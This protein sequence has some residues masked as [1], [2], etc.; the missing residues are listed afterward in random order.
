M[1]EFEPRRSDLNDVVEQRQQRRQ[2]EL[3]RAHSQ[4]ERQRGRETETDR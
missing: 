3:A 4:T 2:G 1:A